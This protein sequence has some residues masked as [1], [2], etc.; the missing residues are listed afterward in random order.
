MKRKLMIVCA[1]VVSSVSLTSY[2][3]IINILRMIENYS[4]AMLGIQRQVLAGQ[5]AMVDMQRRILASQ[6]DIN[7][8]MR[9][10]NGHLSGN[11][12]W[13]TYQF[14]DYQSYG[15]GARDWSSVIEMAARGQG[16]G[17]LG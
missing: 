1:V 5:N 12:G 7:G 15:D 2:A 16:T 8:L 3:G 17:A 4:G 13:G 9:Q 11:S 14:H 10:V 6:Q